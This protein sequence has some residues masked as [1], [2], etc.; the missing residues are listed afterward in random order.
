MVVSVEFDTGRSNLLVLFVLP[1][2]TVSHK[3]VPFKLHRVVREL[4]TYVRVKPTSMAI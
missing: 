1:A 4:S 3:G 2:Y